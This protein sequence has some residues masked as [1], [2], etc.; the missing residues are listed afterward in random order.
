MTWLAVLISALLFVPAALHLLW[1]I[2]AW[3]P[4]RDEAA[5]AR[6]TVGAPGITRMP[7]PIPCALVFVALLFAAALPHLTTFP[8]RTP[9][10]LAIAAVFLLRG[11]AAYLPAW[12]KLV[13]EQPF[14][15]LDQRYYGPLCIVVGASFLLFT[16][17]GA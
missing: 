14:S 8:L 6:A 4:I 12:R 3:V 1:A 13:P 16:L 9:L 15:R 11:V 2:G 10:L 7:G 17:T 5:L